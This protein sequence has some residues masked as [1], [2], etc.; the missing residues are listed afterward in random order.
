MLYVSYVI[1]WLNALIILL[2]GICAADSLVPT[3]LPIYISL[4][5]LC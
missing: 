4:P 5:G 1:G 2:N 3:R